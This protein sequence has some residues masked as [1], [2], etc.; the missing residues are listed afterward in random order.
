MAD[1]TKRTDQRVSETG[2][3]FLFVAIIFGRRRK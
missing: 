2:N 1:V 3:R